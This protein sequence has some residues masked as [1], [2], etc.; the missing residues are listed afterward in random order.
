M[1]SE[2]SAQESSTT[3]TIKRI[4]PPLVVAS[5]LGSTMGIVIAQFL[6]DL[7]DGLLAY[8]L[9]G[10]AVVYNNRAEISG[11]SDLAWAGG[12]LL[13]LIVGFL[14]LFAYPTARGHGTARLALLWMLLNILRQALGQ[15]ILLPF[16]PD[17]QLGL[18]YATFDAPPG[19]NVVIA[20]GGAVG[21]LLIVLSSASAF[22]AFT[23]H[24]RMIN[25]G[26][27]RFTFALWIALVPAV[28]AVFLAIPFFT[29][30]AG[31]GVIPSL[32]LTA[33]IFLATVAAAPGTNTVQGPED[34]QTTPWPWGLGATLFVM[35]LF[36]I[37]VLRGGVSIDP[38]LWG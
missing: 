10:Q 3:E 13:C 9:D 27:K 4:G 31:S 24:H 28:I 15:A 8:I 23:P 12:F 34:S 2:V 7:G 6:D 18:A 1:T 32:P 5:V 19:L 35:L 20:V 38:T 14:V 33:V 17:G 25:N 29:P 37:F 11:V 30:D 22:L 36:S 26:R 16:D 21:L